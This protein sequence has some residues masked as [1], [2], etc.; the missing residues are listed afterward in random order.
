MK[1]LG[2]GGGG[3]QRGEGPLPSRAQRQ[4]CVDK[5]HPSLPPWPCRT[6]E[7]WVNTLLPSHSS[8]LPP[9]LECHLGGSWAGQEGWAGAGDRQVGPLV[10]TQAVLTVSVTVVSEPPCSPWGPAVA[11]APEAEVGEPAAVPPVLQ[12][13]SSTR[14][15]L[16]P[17]APTRT[18]SA[19]ATTASRAQAGV[20]RGGG[21]KPE[22]AWD[23]PPPLPGL[24]APGEGRVLAPGPPHLHACVPAGRRH[25]GKQPYGASSC[26]C[27]LGQL[28][29]GRAPRPPALPAPESSPAVVLEIS[30]TST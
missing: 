18:S 22:A 27:E 8:L 17:T 4:G 11:A 26:T 10:P 28:G 20:G 29:S 9:R 1:G 15:S 14:P 7:A 6:L 13:S 3:P 2:V 12:A 5:P 16:A 21:P 25:S 24:P 23:P 19:L 30:G